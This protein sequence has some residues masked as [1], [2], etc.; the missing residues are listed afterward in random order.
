MRLAKDRRGIP[1]PRTNPPTVASGV[2]TIESLRGFCR[3]VNLRRVREKIIAMHQL[4]MI[5]DS[6]RDTLLARHAA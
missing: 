6:T 5:D 3:A 2:A 4:A 1:L